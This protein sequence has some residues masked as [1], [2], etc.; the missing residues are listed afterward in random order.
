M[1]SSTSVEVELGAIEEE[2]LG[3]MEE[4]EGAT[5]EELGA[6]LSEEETGPGILL[7]IEL[8][9][10]I[11]EGMELQ[12]IELTGVVDDEDV[13]EEDLLVEEREVREDLLE[14]LDEDFEELGASEEATGV[15]EAQERSEV[16]MTSQWPLF[17]R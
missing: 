13:V 3:A 12:G 9:G 17:L 1:D 4:L 2:L 8:T 6:M 15:E 11:L 14:E 10:G 7:G 5:E 16:W